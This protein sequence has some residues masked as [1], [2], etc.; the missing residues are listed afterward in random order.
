MTADEKQTWRN[1][2][3]QALDNHWNSF[4]EQIF[5]SALYAIRTVDS[6][7]WDTAEMHEIV[8]EVLGG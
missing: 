7:R 6:E 1:A 5:E 4:K 2:C 8:S 3:D